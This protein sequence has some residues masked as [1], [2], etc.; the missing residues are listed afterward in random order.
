MTATRIALQL[1]MHVAVQ[2]NRLNP[3]NQFLERSEELV[4]HANWNFYTKIKGRRCLL[5][6]QVFFVFQV[7]LSGILQ[8]G[9]LLIFND[10]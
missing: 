2:T 9:L 1:N 6:R 7:V 5:C 4:V 3:Q 8:T 10:K